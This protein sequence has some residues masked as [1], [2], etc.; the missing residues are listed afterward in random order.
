VRVRVFARARGYPSSHL[1]L[2]TNTVP[3]C[4]TLFTDEIME[5]ANQRSDA[6]YGNSGPQEDG[7]YIVQGDFQDQADAKW[8]V[9][10]GLLRGHNDT[11]F[12]WPTPGRPPGG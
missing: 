9:I 8:I 10:G 11:P 4:S 1:P 2:I 12:G 3:L 5:R 6:M 7:T